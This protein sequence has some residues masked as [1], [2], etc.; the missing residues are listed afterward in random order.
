MF[1]SNFQLLAIL[2]WHAKG[3]NMVNVLGMSNKAILISILFS[4]LV[5]AETGQSE[6]ADMSD[7]LAVY[8]QIG[9][10]ITDRGI[11][12]KFGQVYDTGDDTTAAMNVVEAK[13]FFGDAL[14]WSNTV[15]PDDSI[16]SFR[17]RQFHVDLTTF[18]G[19]QLDANYDVAR[20]AL[21]LSY[22]LLQALPPLGAF[23]FY[24]LAGAGVTVQNNAVDSVA[25]GTPVIDEG[26]SIPGVYGLV[27]MFAKWT[28]SEKTWI[29]YNPT[30]LFS[31]AGSD[32]YLDNSYGIDNSNILLHEVVFSYQLN[33]RT[34]IRYFANFSDEVSFGDGEHKIEFNYQL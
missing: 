8:S 6:A 31:L 12:I 22:S 20:E 28:T 34:N 16:D 23:N 29:N 32:Y 14:G 21:D 33:P 10:G 13:G 11:N 26:F 19:S 15:E 4:P 3:K 18:R 27:G 17:F 1:N 2:M 30:F 25:N 24:P 9:A 5:Y 7:P